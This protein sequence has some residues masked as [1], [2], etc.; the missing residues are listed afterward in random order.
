[1]GILAWIVVGLVAGWLASRVMKGRGSG[2]LGDLVLGVVGALLGGFLASALLKMPDAV[3]G[4]NVM[5]IIVAFV[6]AVILVALLRAVSGR[7]RLF[8]V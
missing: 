3:N 4:I 1:M 2:L 7:R 8:R 5:S 6:G